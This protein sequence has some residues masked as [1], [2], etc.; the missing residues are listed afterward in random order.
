MD[1]ATAKELVVRDDIEVI[2]DLRDGEASSGEEVVFW[3]SDLTHDFVTINSGI[4]N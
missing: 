3:T 1:E 2:L 4:A